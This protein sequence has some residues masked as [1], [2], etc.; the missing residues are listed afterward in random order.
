MQLR[1]S[2]SAFVRSI[3]AAVW[4]LLI[5]ATDAGGWLVFI[6]AWRYYPCM[7][8]GTTPQVRFCCS[9]LTVCEFM[10]FHRPRASVGV[11]HGDFERRYSMWCA[12]AVLVRVS[13]LTVLAVHV[14]SMRCAL[15]FTGFIALLFP[16]AHSPRISG[17]V[18][19]VSWPRRLVACPQACIV[20]S[21][22]S[23]KQIELEITA[24]CLCRSLQ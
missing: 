8:G 18:F 13:I 2:P 9:P 24:C 6:H 3:T 19:T 12:R 1:N 11:A 16:M 10:G 7:R 14:C 17:F 23:Q 22:T 5:G 15:F 20:P 4:R 21:E